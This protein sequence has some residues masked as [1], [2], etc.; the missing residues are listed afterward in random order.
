MEFSL[1]KEGGERRLPIALMAARIVK[2]I[3]RAVAGT[4]RMASTG[5]AEQRSN[6][7]KGGRYAF[8]RFLRHFPTRHA[9]P[10]ASRQKP[11]QIRWKYPTATGILQQTTK[12]A[13]SAAP[14]ENPPLSIQL[15]CTCTWD[16]KVSDSLAGKTI[17]CPDC[18]GSIQVPAATPATASPPL[19]D[20]AAA[21]SNTKPGASTFTAEAA[22]IQSHFSSKAFDGNTLGSP[23]SRQTQPNEKIQ[24]SWDLETSAEQDPA[25]TNPFATT[26]YSDDHQTEGQRRDV[27]NAHPIIRLGSRLVE[28]LVLA[29]ASIPGIAVISLGQYLRHPEVVIAGFGLLLVTFVCLAV[30]TV[31]LFSQGKSIGRKLVSLTVLDE[32]TGEPAGFGK[33]FLREVLPYLLTIVALFLIGMLGVLIML[34]FTVVDLF[35]I[36]RKDHRRITDRICG[37]H[38]VAD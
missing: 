17:R 16:G 19:F 38:V 36:F 14:P 9:H 37:T 10:P 6:S 4:N 34:L 35:S 11:A 8:C 5:M 23:P 24:G 12:A 3:Q 28:N 29:A 1:R 18:G 20:S 25:S 33:T 15:R 30:Y 26:R 2:I 27:I 7:L 31:R 32:H 13:T 22:A 21:A